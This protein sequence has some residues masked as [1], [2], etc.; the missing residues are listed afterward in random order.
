MAHY[1]RLW[2]CKQLLFTQNLLS[3]GLNLYPVTWQGMGLGGLIKQWMLPRMQG[4]I[5]SRVYQTTRVLLVELTTC[6]PWPLGQDGQEWNPR[7]WWIPE[8]AWNYCC[9]EGICWLISIL[10]F[11]W[12]IKLSIHSQKMFFKFDRN[13]SGTLEK[14][15]VAAALQNLG[16]ANLPML[17]SYKKKKKSSNLV[18]FSHWACNPLPLTLPSPSRLSIFSFPLSFFSPPFLPSSL[19]PFLSSSFPL[20]SLPHSRL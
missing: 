20:F 15:E 7:L 19:P 1:N 13:R 18:P 11:C 8:V 5:G 9:L 12:W 10:K 6:I 2:T 4:W 14:A 3:A 16:M 17:A